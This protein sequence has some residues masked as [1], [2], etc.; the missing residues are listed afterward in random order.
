MENK[1]CSV[2]YKELSDASESVWLECG[3]T[4]EEN[5]PDLN[6]DNYII[7]VDGKE[8]N[9]NHVVKENDHIVLRAVPKG[10]VAIAVAIIAVCVVAAVVVGVLIYN[11]KKKAKQNTQTS[12][13]ADVDD[14][15]QNKP[16]LKGA[17]NQV[18]TGKTQPYVIGEHLFTPYILNSGGNNY[19][20]VSTIGGTDG[21]DQYYSVVL[22]GG[23]GKQVLRKL[24]CDDVVLKTWADTETVPQEGVYSFDESSIFYDDE[25]FIEVAQDG[26]QFETNDFIYKI[27]ENQCNT[28]LGKSD[29]TNYS[30]LLFQLE[31]STMAADVC[32]I[33]NGLLAYT[34]EGNKIERTV[35]V[36]PEYSLDGGN[37]YTPF[38]FNQNGTL[39]NT[40]KRKTID[41]LRFN[42]HIDFTYAQVKD[43]E[44]PVVIRVN[45]E[46]PAYDGSCYDDCYVGWV[47]SYIYNPDLSK[48]QNAFVPEKIIDSLEAGLSTLVGLKIRS[49]VDN[50]D[51]LTMINV[52]SSGVAR[53]WNGTSWSN[54]KVPTRNPAAWIVEVLTSPSHVPSKCSDDEIDF[55]SFGELYEYCEDQ[56]YCIDMVLTDGQ[57]KESLL[58][59]MVSTCD[60]VLYRNMF[61]KIAVAIDT[62]KQNAVAVFNPQNIVSFEYSKEF[63]RDTDGIKITYTSRAG[64]YVEDTYLVMQEGRTRNSESVLREQQVKGI[65][66]HD[67]IVKNARRTMATATLR[68]KT[69]TIQC[70]KEAEYFTPLSKILVQHPSL[71]IGLGH[72]EIKSVITNAG[73]IIGLELYEPIEYESEDERGFGV[74][75]QAVSE[76]YCAPLGF[77]YTAP[78]NGRVTEI[79]FITPLSV[80]ANHV[81]HAGDVLSY[82]YLN[83]GAFETI[84]SPY[85][86]ASMEPT[87]N[88]FKLSCVDY[89]EAIYETGE[90][91]AY[92]P[93]LTQPRQPV[94]QVEKPSDSLEL[95]NTLAAGLI[96]GTKEV[97][98]PSD[99]SALTAQAK[100]STIECVCGNFAVGLKNTIDRI[101][102][103]IKKPGKEWE[104][105]NTAGTTAT[106][107]FDRETDGYPEA[108]NLALWKVRAKAVNVYGYES[109]NWVEAGITTTGY[110]TWQVTEPAVLTRVSDRTITLMLNATARADN[111]QIYGTL[112]YKVQVKRPDIDTAFF[113]PNAG[114]NPYPDG[115]THN[116][117]NYKIAGNTGYIE[118]DGIY[119][120]TMPLK[121][122]SEDNIVDTAYMFSVVLFNE[123]TESEAVEATATALCTSI[124]DLVKANETAKEA[125][126]TQLSA[127]SANVGTI[128][129]GAFG[130]NLN[131]WDLSTFLDEAQNHH[132]EG[133]FRVGGENQYLK[134]EP[135]LNAAG[136]I[137]DYNITFVVGNFELSAT[138]SNING[139]L[140]IMANADALDRTRITPK[141]TF[142]QHRDSLTGDW[143]NVVSLGTNGAN[144][145]QVFNEKTLYL[146]NA[147][148]V[149]RRAGGYDI[150]NQYLSS[151]SIVYHFDDNA[152]D[153]HGNSDIT[154]SSGAVLVGT[155]TE[156]D[157]IDFTPAILSVAP[158]AT[159]GKSLYGQ[160]KLTGSFGQASIFTVDFWLQYIY[161]ENQEL[162]NV[163]T[164]SDRIKL[165]IAAGE[166][167]F[168]ENV[169]DEVPLNEEV[170]MSRLYREIELNPLTINEQ[171]EDEP[172]LNEPQEG[173]IYLNTIAIKEFVP[174]YKYY[175]CDVVEGV[176]QF[177]LA[178]VTAQDYYDYVLTGLY[179]KTL[180]INEPL[181]EHAYIEHVGQTQSEKVELADLGVVFSDNEWLH[182]GVIANANKIILCLNHTSTQFNRYASASDTLT[183]SMNPQENSFLLDEL[184]VDT[185]VAESAAI[186]AEH[187]TNR[188]PWAALAKDED[189]L[190]LFA[191]D[192]NNFKTNIFESAVFKSAV[193]AI[194]DERLN[195][196]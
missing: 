133:S 28:S 6:Y 179:E 154:I 91:P 155:E 36:V 96:E 60:A 141:G 11:M 190:T 32:I 114:G 144:V 4:I 1:V 152:L 169:P 87:D 100:Q 55:D 153:Q 38:Y 186:F 150:G 33:F 57:T 12:S 182:I 24:Y 18:A 25:S 19:K 108:S 137:T 178:N 165:I 168:E 164:T 71:K 106:Y 99:V 16:W 67:H 105:I 65:V 39:S 122:Q 54:N 31:K 61:G 103:E 172:A 5:L 66:E 81:P 44:S 68:P 97:G 14:D 84:T 21:K 23:F 119:T 121:G 173:E 93:N 166:P 7:L 59:D 79:L 42:A 69:V 52:V 157:D 26:E 73:N 188:V 126:I 110:G 2:V 20:G 116:E 48:S 130:R 148:M 162:C 193:E 9:K 135:V 22:E 140:I 78:E 111:K 77:A 80:N 109:S 128:Y 13:K 104:A 175:V 139:E 74:V 161:A 146:T 184:F 124:R 131:Y 195:N 75:V 107:Y 136:N 171:I 85:L 113:K 163:G 90:I 47:H 189:Y 117:Y 176:E 34:D 174:G 145:P 151:N 160:Y 10:M 43:L 177:E 30:P 45:C 158:Y 94:K 183:I 170:R 192:P 29:D 132:Y 83:D 27:V 56:G 51:K 63:V 101:K 125:Y 40:F 127:L 50:E 187:T 180:T 53:I 41:Q 86:I 15:V 129:Q 185:T 118:A 134:V 159:S 3:K 120:Q 17:S 64:N 156:S 181:G 46:T 196:N 115:T 147:S 37:T 142:F 49:T 92:T 138:A 149:Q 123:A 70:G 167:F 194:I 95:V 88:G 76:S 8:S 35:T 98:S 112:R 82:G 143:Y 62:Y 102:Y 191:K 89:N 58:S 72:A